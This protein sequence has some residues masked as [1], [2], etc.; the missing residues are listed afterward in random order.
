MFYCREQRELEKENIELK[1]NLREYFKS[2]AAS[3]DLAEYG[4]LS[5]SR[6]EKP[7]K[8]SRSRR[9]RRSPVKSPNKD[10]PKSVPGGMNRGHSTTES[11]NIDLQ[12]TR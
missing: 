4:L 2:L 6:Q 5:I 1:E 7:T 3:K 8:R 11:I 10:R 9:R 12:R